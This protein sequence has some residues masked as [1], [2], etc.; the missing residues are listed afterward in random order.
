[1]LLAAAAL[2]SC[3]KRP[4]LEPVT[5][6]ES[7]G[8]GI[9]QMVLFSG[10]TTANRETKAADVKTYY[11]PNNYRFV[12][13]MYYKAQTGSEAFD[14]SGGTDQTAWLKVDGNVGNSLYWNKEYNSVNTSIKGKGG[15]DDYGND[16]SATAFYWQNRKEHAFLAWTDL[17]K[18]T[19]IRN[20]SAKGT[21]KF[22]KDLDYKVY[23][24]N[25]IEQ[26]VVTGYNIYGSDQV[27]ESIS[28]IRDYVE[29]N[30]T[31]DEEI[32]AF[33][34]AQN[35][36]G[37]YADWE[38]SSYQYQFGWS[39][40]HTTH[41][42]DDATLID[43]THRDYKWY[44]YM[45][46]F[47]KTE[48]NMEGELG[49]Y[50]KI[51]IE[52]NN[53]NM[54]IFRL[55][56]DGIIVAEAEVTNELNGEGHYVDSEGNVISNMDLLTYNFY[57]TDANGNVRYNEETPRFI[58]YYKRSEEKKSIEEYNEFAALAFDLTRGSKTGINQQP[59][60]V[61]A[62]EIQAPVG[63]TQEANRVNLYFKHMF[64]QVQVN[65]KNA[66]DNSVTLDAGDIKKV[67]LLGVTE[68]GY[69]F[70]ELDA[71]GKVKEAAYKEV[72]FSKYTEDQLKENT[73]GTSLQMFEL[74]QAETGYLKSFNA[75]TFGQL[76]AIRMTWKEKDTEYT[77]AATFRIPDTEHM[78]LKSGTK[79]VWNIEVRR[80][81]L[82][83]IR[84]EIIDWE[85]PADD[86][87]NG[88]TSGTIVND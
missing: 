4:E 38:S 64:S 57:E 15:V 3:E 67:E 76:Q 17:N 56:K 8:K 40:K 58:F 32:A 42:T 78:N 71:E 20:G 80:G 11:M 22:G 86:A 59:D 27:F 34:A 75:I 50:E 7:D 1:M 69:I 14:V 31:T 36:M 19:S 77:H 26:W 41:A 39:C 66:A 13:R 30:Y 23:T 85:Y 68:E 81:T 46:F 18:A 12:C 63:A 45:M 29:K 10:G 49:D 5:G 55:K 72:D 47:E 73:Y 60:I 84:T 61:Q 87:H 16:Y 82:A 62:L 48:F 51:Y 74:G 28:A 79:Y 24:G 33:N 88:H 35:Q 37:G 21:L 44:R 54:V 25:K 70:T 52:D 6:P 83:I 53:H 65:I 2:W 43:P 9:G